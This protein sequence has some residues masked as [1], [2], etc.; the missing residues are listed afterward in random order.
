MVDWSPWPFCTRMANVIRTGT[1]NGNQEINPY[2]SDR[3][4]NGVHVFSGVKRN[5]EFCTF[6]HSVPPRNGT[7]HKWRFR[8]GEQT[9]TIW[10]QSEKFTRGL[11][12]L[13]L[14][15][16]SMVSSAKK[17][18]CGQTTEEKIIDFGKFSPPQLQ[19]KMLCLKKEKK[20]ATHLKIGDAPWCHRISSP[21]KI[22][23][24][25]SSPPNSNLP[26]RLIPFSFGLSSFF[27][28]CRCFCIVETTCLRT[29]IPIIHLIQLIESHLQNRFHLY[30][31]P[32]YGINPG[33]MKQILLSGSPKSHNKIRVLK[34]KNGAKWMAL[35]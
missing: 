1:G 31:N 32:R 10:K 21:S 34:D 27:E 30:R 23:F 25:S 4:D 20:K 13:L 6:C 18:K 19:R 33:I 3:M 26:F 11:S 12:F 7:A 2:L 24:D 22:A 8:N 17:D 9:R 28:S 15:M 5:M 35:M 14:P 29:F 16:H